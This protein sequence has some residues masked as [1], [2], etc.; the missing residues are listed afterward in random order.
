M[1]RQEEIYRKIRI[2][3]LPDEAGENSPS[4]EEAISSIKEISDEIGA[5]RTSEELIPFIFNFSTY[6]T[7]EIVKTLNEFATISFENYKDSEISS[8]LENFSVVFTRET[9]SIRKA[10][11]NTFYI[12]IRNS[13]KLEIISKILTKLTKNKD[14]NS[15]RAACSITQQISS[16][17]DEENFL[18]IF[19]IIEEL[20]KDENCFVKKEFV[21]CLAHV[22][23]KF[24]KNELI[25]VKKWLLEHAKSNILSVLIEI[26]SATIELV[27]HDSDA[28]IV[29][30]CEALMSH[31]NWR[32]IT[33][34]MNSMNLLLVKEQQAESYLTFIEKAIKSND[35]EVCASGIN[36]IQ[37]YVKLAASSIQEERI[38]KALAPVIKSNNTLILSAIAENISIM[39][40][41]DKLKAFALETAKKLISMNKED[42]TSNVVSNT[43][44]IDKEYLFKV[45]EQGKSF[46][47]WRQRLT[48]A[49]ALPKICEG[50]NEEEKTRFTDLFISYLL[51]EAIGLRSTV[52]D[53]M[54]EVI[55]NLGVDWVLKDLIHKLSD[56]YNNTFDYQEKQT[57]I[58]AIVK[59][60]ILDLVEENQSSEKEVVYSIIEK[61]TEDPIANVRYICASVLPPNSHFI[62]ILKDDKDEDVRDLAKSRIV[63]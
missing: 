19:K 24:P 49:E 62:E 25:N 51:D 59:S 17:F 60:G 26:P 13:P 34:T 37:Y 41:F 31:N 14:A 33:T 63:V 16:L 53:L 48:I 35:E 46:E 52:I 12:V 54:K 6:Y 15:R 2:L 50:L 43:A 28:D 9:A 55:Q 58:C 10:A 27:K 57:I 56:I 36:Q 30:I 61:A 45:L 20:N 4:L 29:D 3:G 47:D 42:I 40:S 22:M 7:K 44:N 21:K 8:F 32:V 11:L 38:G 18:K 1:Q 23:N 5:K 39:M